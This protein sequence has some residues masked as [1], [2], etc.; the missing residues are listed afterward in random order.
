MCRMIDPSKSMKFINDGY[1]LVHRTSTICN[2][3][4]EELKKNKNETAFFFEQDYNYVLVKTSK[5]VEIIAK[6][7]DGA[8]SRFLKARLEAKIEWIGQLH[9]GFLATDF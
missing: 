2:Q 3:F 5:L 8:Y 6:K 9:Y 4:V 1:S 7:F